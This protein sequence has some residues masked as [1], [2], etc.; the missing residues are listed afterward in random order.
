[1]VVFLA[2]ASGSHF[3]EFGQVSIPSNFVITSDGR[4]VTWF[5]QNNFSIS[6]QSGQVFLSQL[7]NQHGRRI[8]RKQN[9]QQYKDTSCRHVLKI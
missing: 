9:Q 7:P 5:V 2:Y 8:E 4:K 6:R 1:M 3:E